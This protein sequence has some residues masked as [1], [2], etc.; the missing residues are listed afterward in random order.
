MLVA[1]DCIPVTC[2]YQLLITGITVGKETAWQWL[3]LITGIVYPLKRDFDKT[4]SYSDMISCIKKAAMV[5]TWR[6]KDFKPI[7]E[8][9]KRKG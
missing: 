8:Q 6:D 9:I 1:I 5:K 3:D 7:T 4:M 2:V